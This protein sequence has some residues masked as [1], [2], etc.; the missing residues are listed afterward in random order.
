MTI[1][2]KVKRVLLSHSQKTTFYP[3]CGKRFESE[4]Q[5]LQH[6]NQ[7]LSACQ[8]FVDDLSS[9][10]VSQP[11]S[12]QAL[13]LSIPD[14]YGSHNAPEPSLPP[15]DNLMAMEPDDLLH[16]EQGSGPLPADIEATPMNVKV[17]LGASMSY[18]SGLTFM[19]NFFADEHGELCKENIFYPFA[20]QEDWQVALWLLHSRLSMAAIDSFLSLELSWVLHPQNLT[21]QVMTLFYCDPIECLQSLLSHP[22]FEPHI[23]FIPRKVWSMAAQISNHM[24]HPLLLSLANISMDICSKGSLHGHM[25]LTL[26][27]VP[28]FIHKKSCVCSLLSD[29]LFHHCLDL[30]LKPLKIAATVGDMMNNPCGNVRY[31]FTLLV[32]YITDTPKQSLL[33]CMS[34]RVSSMST[35]T[36]REFSDNTCHLPRMG[37]QTLANIRAVHAKAN[38]DDFL[39]FLKAAKSYGL[40]GVHE[41][42]WRDWPLLDPGQFL[43]IKPLHHFFRMFWDHDMKWCIMAIGEDEIDYCFS[44]IQMPVGYHSFTDGVLKLKQVTGHDHHSI[45]QYILSIVTGTVPV[46]FLAAICGLLDF[47]YLVQM[48]AFD[49]CALAK[50]NTALD[51]F[52]AHKHAVLAIGGCSEHF[53]IP[54]LELM[55]HV[56]TSIRTSGVPMQWSADVTKHAHVTKIKN[57]AHA[58]NNQNYYAQIVCHLNCSESNSD[59]YDNQDD[60]LDEE[61]SHPLLS[62]SPTCKVIEYFEV[63]HTIAHSP[64]PDPPKLLSLWMTIDEAVTL[65]EL[66]DLHPVILDYLD[67]CARAIDH[68]ITGQ[69]HAV[70]GRSLPSN[71]LQIWAKVHIQVRNYHNPRNVEPAQTM[72]ATP[73]SKEHPCR[74]Y[75]STVFSPAGDSDWPDQGLNADYF[76]RAMVVQLRLVFHI[77][78]LEEFLAYVQHFHITSSPA[79]HTTDAAAAGLHVLKHAMRSNGECGKDFRAEMLDSELMTELRDAMITEPLGMHFIAYWSW[80]SHLEIEDIKTSNLMNVGKTQINACFLKKYC[81]MLACT[82]LRVLVHPVVPPLLCSPVLPALGNTFEVLSEYAAKPV[83]HSHIAVKPDIIFCGQPDINSGFAWSHVISFLELTSTQY[84]KHLECN[85]THK[86]YAVFTTQLHLGFDPTF[87]NPALSPS[88]LYCPITDTALKAAW[89]IKVENHLYTVLGCIFTSNII[90]GRAMSSWGRRHTEEEILNKIK[91]LKGVPTLDVVWMVQIDRND[92]MTALLWPASIFGS[93]SFETCIH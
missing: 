61:R 93:T 25:L 76:P 64:P 14:C 69:R 79:D 35:V 11:T 52:H 81:E 24:A 70:P 16:H 36:H 33:A 6:M 13:L 83:E 48:P 54:K 84:T 46:T 21:K 9:I 43:K 47:H 67:H 50:L 89:M 56:V 34:P 39:D 57:P 62:Y 78:G 77:L 45:Q 75:D 4:T 30:V 2:P 74:L 7:P 22:L 58:G 20:S 51:S 38:V 37:T 87:L 60:E 82:R 40:N 42:F 91:D 72:N 90:Q 5:V 19:D 44:L 32:G 17:Y 53:H 88:P 55:Q 15:Q 80:L 41:P 59:N 65:Y 66:P 73:L 92:E 49:E 63:T 26:L 12:S 85:I 27:P 28:S 31:C 71:R 29:Q 23:S 1:M 10:T 3:S 86:V 8:S 68:D 18:V